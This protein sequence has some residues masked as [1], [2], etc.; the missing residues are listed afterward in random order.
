MSIC[1]HAHTHTLSTHTFSCS[2]PTHSSPI[3]LH[4]VILHKNVGKSSQMPSRSTSTFLRNS[5]GG[6]QRGGTFFFKILFIHERY[7][8]RGWDIGQREKQVPWGEPNV[9]LGPGTLGPQPEPKADAQ[10]LSHPGF[11][12]AGTFD[13]QKLRVPPSWVWPWL[14]EKLTM[15]RLLSL[16]P[17]WLESSLVQRQTYVWCHKFTLAIRLAESCVLEL[18]QE[19]IEEIMTFQLTLTSS[20][21]QYS[22]RP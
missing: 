4:R 16:S 1:F 5:W 10:P 14:P 11:L 8:E 21:R 20:I 12:R 15:L 13:G 22:M 2:H 3:P 19:I 17:H 18:Y 9:G 7:T 6:S